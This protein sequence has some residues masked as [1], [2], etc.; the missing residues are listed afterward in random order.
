MKTIKEYLNRNK[1]ENKINNIIFDLD[2]ESYNLLD[3]EFIKIL[4]SNNYILSYNMIFEALR[5]LYKSNDGDELKISN[6]ANERR[7][8]P[9]EQ[10]GDGKQP[11]KQNEIINMFR[12]VWDDIIDMDL[13]GKLS[14]FEYNQRLVNSWVLECQYWL[15]NNSENEIVCTGAR[16]K[17]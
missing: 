3:D 14:P 1:F 6:H 8:R 15:K 17:I 7:N 11:I 12:W 9:I 4:E 13:N 10:G 2:E 5:V 16:P